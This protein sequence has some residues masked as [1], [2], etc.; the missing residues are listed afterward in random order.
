MRLENN[1]LLEMLIQLVDFLEFD[2]KILRTIK[3]STN[4][5]RSFFKD[6]KRIVKEIGYYLNN[7]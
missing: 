1:F 5:T 6:P 4:Y 3:K 2:L 7:N